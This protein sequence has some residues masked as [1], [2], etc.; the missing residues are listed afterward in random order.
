MEKQSMV[1]AVSSFGY[2]QFH[3]NDL[4]EKSGRG[5]GA[6]NYFLLKEMSNGRIKR[7][8]KGMY[9]A[10]A[11]IKEKT[12]EKKEVSA[13]EVGNSIIELVESLREE[14]KE[15]KEEKEELKEEV[16]E[17]KGLMDDYDSILNCNRE[18]QGR[19]QEL[20]LEIVSLKGEKKLEI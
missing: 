10:T 14:I 20:S 4:I 19:V 16:E 18:L 5:R 8:E 9:K 17:L 3:I 2:N 7:V 6:V 12:S 11:P 13:L 1:N 15:L